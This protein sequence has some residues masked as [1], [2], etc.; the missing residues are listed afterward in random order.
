MPRKLR[1][2]PSAPLG[3]RARGRSSPSR[4]TRIAKGRPSNTTKP[5]FDVTTADGTVETFTDPEEAWT[6]ALSALNEASSRGEVALEE[7][8]KLN[9]AFLAGLREAGLEDL[10]DSLNRAYGTAVDELG[11]A[12]RAE[13]LRKHETRSDAAVRKATEAESANRP[14]EAQKPPVES[15]PEPRPETTDQKPP[16]ATASAAAGAPAQA[17]TGEKKA[18]P[19]QRKP[20]A[21]MPKSPLATKKPNEWP[22]WTEQFLRRIKTAEEAEIGGLYNQFLVEI[23]FAEENRQADH[24]RIMAAFDDRRK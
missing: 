4:Q 21:Q 6:A 15:K 1:R 22:T 11:K 8:W 12:R 2:R 16:P 3:P 13:E 14:A 7:V 18:E 17:A 5:A 9:A 24:V 19:Q 10:A 20:P 23:E